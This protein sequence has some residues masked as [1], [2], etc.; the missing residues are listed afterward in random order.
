M[1]A[2]G[3]S[4][5]RLVA[6]FS[7]TALPKWTEI[8]WEAPIGYG[9]FCI[10]FPQSRM[11]GERHRLSSVCWASS[12]ILLCFNIDYNCFVNQYQLYHKTQIICK[13]GATC[14]KKQGDLNF[15][16]ESR[17]G[18]FSRY[19]VR[20][21]PGLVSPAFNNISVISLRLVLMDGGTRRK[22]PTCRKSLTNFIT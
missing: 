10:K 9:R 17:E 21:S 13:K 4:C 1:A 5:F 16:L 6:F 12:L 22:P 14:K 8:W 2:T 3:N 20:I 19:R 15:A 11:K 7:E 18:D